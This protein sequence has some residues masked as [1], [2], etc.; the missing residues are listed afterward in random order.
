MGRGEGEERGEGQSADESAV[1]SCCI[2]FPHRLSHATR[3][4]AQPYEGAREVQSARRPI[5]GD[6]SKDTERKKG[7]ENKQDRSRR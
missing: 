2:L 3:S 5:R 6:D 4:D 1:V 7:S